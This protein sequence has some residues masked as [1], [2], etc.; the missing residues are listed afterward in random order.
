MTVSCLSAC[1]I[2]GT[3]TP[4]PYSCF[5]PFFV[6]PLPLLFS[7]LLILLQ[8]IILGF[9]L[10]SRFSPCLSPASFR[11]VH[12]RRSTEQ[13]GGTSCLYMPHCTV[14]PPV[15]LLIHISVCLPVHL[16]DCLFTFI[17]SSFFLFVPLIIT[18]IPWNLYF[19]FAGPLLAILEVL[20]S[21]ELIVPLTLCLDLFIFFTR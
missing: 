15:S 18:H 3:L 9:S 13:C 7:C 1:H 19:L 6:F 20:R 10:L 2:F 16:H 8:S 4:P 5:P 21:L 14:T 11:S 12:H 17:F